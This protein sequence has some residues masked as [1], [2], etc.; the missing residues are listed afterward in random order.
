MIIIKKIILFNTFTQNTNECTSS[1]YALAKKIDFEVIKK[2]NTLSTNFWDIENCSEIFSNYHYSFVKELGNTI[3]T[4][5]SF[6]LYRIIKLNAFKV[7][8]KYIKTAFIMLI[9]EKSSHSNDI[10]LIINCTSHFIK[11]LNPWNSLDL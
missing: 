6:T 9:N 8:V 5:S 11:K 3:K 7:L 10:Q 2:D 4:L 1:Y